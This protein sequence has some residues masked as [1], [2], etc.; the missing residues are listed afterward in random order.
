MSTNNI[1][2]IQNCTSFDTPELT[3][4]YRGAN[5]PFDVSGPEP[6]NITTPLYTTHAVAPKIIPWLP[7]SSSSLI[8]PTKQPT[9]VPL[10]PSYRPN[11]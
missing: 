7:S 10:R 8:G 5:S 4:R 1:N 6:N 9:Q 2:N 11:C 3:T